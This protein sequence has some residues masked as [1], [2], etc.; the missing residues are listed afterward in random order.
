[1]GCRLPHVAARCRWNET[2]PKPGKT[3]S[4]G[5]LGGVRGVGICCKYLKLNGT[6]GRARTYNLLIRS[7][8][9]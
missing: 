1:M 2:V 8:K 5:K 4:K 7:Q 6:A 3:V 9:L